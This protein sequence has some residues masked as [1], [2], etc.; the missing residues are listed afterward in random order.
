MFEKELRKKEEIPIFMS[1]GK[2]IIEPTSTAIASILA[3]TKSYIKFYILMNTQDAFTP[4][5]KKKLES[6]KKD[7]KNF[8]INYIDINP[9]KF[10]S[11]SNSIVGYIK[12]DTYFRFLIPQ[13]VTNIDKAIYLDYDIIA[14]KDISELY[15]IDLEGKLIG[16]ICKEK[17]EYMSPFLKK[18]ISKTGIKNIYSYFNAG[19]LLLDCKAMRENNITEKLFET[20]KKW[21]DKVVFADQDI[22]N[23]VFEDKYKELEEKYN[24][25]P[26]RIKNTQDVNIIHYVTEEKPW[27][28]DCPNHW[29]F[30]EYAKKYS[31]YYN[32]LMDKRYHYNFVKKIFSIKNARNNYKIICIL[33]LKFKIKKNKLKRIFSIKNTPRR[34]NYRIA[35]FRFSIKKHIHVPKKIKIYFLLHSK[36]FLPSW[37]SFIEACK[38][39]ERIITKIIY[40]PVAKQAKDRDG[41]FDGTE[42]WLK[43]N[44]IEYVH[45]NKI[46]LHIDRPNVLFYQ[47]PYSGH[48]HKNN[49]SGYFKKYGIKPAYISYGL[50]FTEAPLNIQNHFKL[51]IHKNSWRIY[52]FS[53]NLVKDYWKYCPIGN[54]HVRCFGHPKFDALYEAKNIEMPQWL[55]DKIKGRRIICWHVHFPCAYSNDNGELKLSTLSWED[56]NEILNYIK[57]DKE[58]FYIFMPHHM[59]FG[60]TTTYY[61]LN[62]HEVKLFKKE[63][64]EGENSTVWEEEYPEVLHWSDIFLSERSAVTMEM[65]TTNKPV[66]YLEGCPEIYNEFGKDV[67]NAYYYANNANST[68]SLLEK[69]KN[70]E[71]TK[72]LEREKVFEKYIESYYDGKCGERIK[73]DIINS[74][75]EIRNIFIENLYLYLKF[76]IKKISRKIFSIKFQKRILETHIVICILGIKF[77]IRL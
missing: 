53:E 19:V 31:P 32:E 40:C 37:K 24:E 28:V 49:D 44:N 18:I 77:K 50:E 59:F 66:I 14:L 61:N 23:I 41:Q 65:I 15:N 55:K 5:D 74:Y 35:G 36:A 10:D 69:L 38:K 21:N 39:D 67:I 57:N 33:G 42:E 72:K 4:K 60:T 54:S 20:T 75:E 76:Y 63:L 22:L 52:T 45:Y 1:I 46:N 70:G 68:I 62:P 12:I 3:N 17:G 43:E 29:I 73:N 16:A 13:L 8:E 2:S 26:Y 25:Y 56:D 30:W 11:L 51:A 7:F 64:L 48:R 27:L 47:T 58:N 6:L 9:E 71:D 34:K